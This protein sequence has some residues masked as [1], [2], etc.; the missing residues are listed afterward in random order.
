ME[1]IRAT[2]K[3]VT[4]MMG[5]MRNLLK[6]IK[7]PHLKILVDRFLSDSHFVTLFKKAPA[8]KNFHH[9]YLGG[10]LEH[11]LSVCQMSS[12]MKLLLNKVVMSTV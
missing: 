9:N 12:L 2:T 5:S 6:E 10:L 7:N 8:A 1:V 4:E 11:T 3:N